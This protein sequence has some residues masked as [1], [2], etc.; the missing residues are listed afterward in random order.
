MRIG[1]TTCLVLQI[2]TGKT[3]PFGRGRRRC[4]RR[5]AR[6]SHYFSSLP[7]P[8]GVLSALTKIPK[9]CLIQITLKAP[10]FSY[11]RASDSHCVGHPSGILFTRRRSDGLSTQQ[12]GL[13]RGFH[14]EAKKDE[15]SDYETGARRGI[16][17]G[18]RG[19]VDRWGRRMASLPLS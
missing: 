13:G 5:G 4:P 8:G 6:G 1:Q 11:C 12:T 9:R 2:R 18:G 15:Q 17:C 7:D 10:V 16:C 14:Q 19:G 3:C